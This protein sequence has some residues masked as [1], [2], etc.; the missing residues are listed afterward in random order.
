MPK[1]RD[2]VLRIVKSLETTEDWDSEVRYNHVNYTHNECGITL[3]VSHKCDWLVLNVYEV[4]S[5]D[6]TNKEI[7]ALTQHLDNLVYVYN[8]TKKRQVNTE[9]LSCVKLDIK[10]TKQKLNS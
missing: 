6:L 9:F 10:Q 5:I 4:K 3:L 7:K 2:F 1:I 8:H